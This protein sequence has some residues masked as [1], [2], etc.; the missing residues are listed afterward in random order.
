MKISYVANHAEMTALS[1]L[2]IERHRGRVSLS[3]TETGVIAEVD[4]AD[5]SA[6]ANIED[7]LAAAGVHALALAA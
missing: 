3:F 2:L 4:V 7:A 1:R 5:R 6:A